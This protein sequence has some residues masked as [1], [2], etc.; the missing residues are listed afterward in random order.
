MIKQNWMLI[1]AGENLV[2]AMTAETKAHCEWTGRGYRSD[3][4]CTLQREHAAKNIVGAEVIVT[5]MGCSVRYDSG[6]QNFGLLAGSK[7]GMLDGSLGHAEQWAR[8]WVSKDPARRYAW[9]RKMAI[10]VA[11]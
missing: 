7:S 6:L 8:E 1:I 3:D 5:S 10:E 4:V 11:A 9:R 2:D